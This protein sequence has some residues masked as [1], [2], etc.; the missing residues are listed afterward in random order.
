[1]PGR[2]SADQG[3]VEGTV[4]AALSHS[5]EHRR[6]R[7]AWLRRVLGPPAQG[8]RGILP[9]RRGRSGNRAGQQSVCAIQATFSERLRICHQR[10]MQKGKGKSRDAQ[11]LQNQENRSTSARVQN[12][13][14]APFSKSGVKYKIQH[15]VQ[16]ECP[17]ALWGALSRIASCKLELLPFPLHLYRPRL[18]RCRIPDPRAQSCTGWTA[19][20]Q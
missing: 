7:G 13:T 17:Y 9:D 3:L 1:M 11:D 19:R 2:L 18:R 10:N 12:S 4:S 6:D 5:H 8:I 15:P 14:C 20:M 16:T